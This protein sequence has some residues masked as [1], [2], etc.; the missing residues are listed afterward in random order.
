MCDSSPADY[1]ANPLFHLVSGVSGVMDRWGVG[2]GT[3]TGPRKP[4]GAV[5]RLGMGGFVKAEKGGT[6]GCTACLECSTPSNLYL[7]P[8][9]SARTTEKTLE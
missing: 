8:D 9:P 2:D 7:H 3:N 1:L 6:Y 4:M 5:A